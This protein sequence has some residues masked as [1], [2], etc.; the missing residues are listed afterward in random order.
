LAHPSQRHSSS[1]CQQLA[2][3]AV[4]VNGQLLA[5]IITVYAA[6]EWVEN[7]VMPSISAAEQHAT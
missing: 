4:T 1:A 2:A 3:N 7:G 6:A 5:G